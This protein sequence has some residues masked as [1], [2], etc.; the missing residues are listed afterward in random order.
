MAGRFDLLRYPALAIVVAATLLFQSNY[1]TNVLLVIGLH[2]LPAIGLSLL[3]GYAGQIS[4]G[5]AAFYGLG[6]YGSALIAIHA[7]ISPWLSMPIAVAIVGFLG[8]ALGWLVFRLKGHYLAMA[9]LG[10]GI[11]V[12]VAFVELREWTGGPNGLQDVPV[13]DFF[14]KDL[15]SDQ[16]FLP[17]IWGALLLAIFF[18]ETLVRSPLGLSLKAIGE[19]EKVAASLGTSPDSYKRLIL[20]VSAA[21]AAVAGGLYAH[22]VGYLSPSPFDVGFS[23]K[24]LVMVAIGGFARI[25]G[26]L[27]GVAFVTVLSELLKP[28]GDYDII[29]FGVLLILTMIFCP[30]GL[31]ERGRRLVAGALRPAR[32]AGA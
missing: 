32:R 6:A 16:T 26:V 7:G 30:E 19:N 12:H 29:L 22:Y 28:F 5:H 23:I 24:L 15:V 13:L 8:W 3:M 4:L 9:T 14:G 31:L 1:I 18:A 2:A 21:Y 20:M 10:L 11:I 27:F 25:W 17:F